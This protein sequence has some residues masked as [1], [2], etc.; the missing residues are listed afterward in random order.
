MSHYVSEVQK[1]LPKVNQILH[2]QLNTIDDEESRIE[3]KSR[4]ADVTDTSIVVEIPLNEKTGKLKK[5]YVG[6]EL[7]TFFLS[8]GG[9]KHYFTT[10]VT[11]F[12]E[13]VIRLVELRKPELE[14]IT[15]VQRR[16]FLRVLAELEIAVKISD[17]IQFIGVTDDV[18]GGGISFI[19]DGHI[20]LGLNAN[21][22]CWVLVPY[23]NGSIEHI[24]FTGEIVRIKKLESGKQLAMIRFIEIA[25]RERQKL[26]RFCFERQMDFRKR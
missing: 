10:S 14:A 25:D 7:S 23:K 11:G 19:C 15:Q 22:S 4:I 16:S 24:P 2:I 18:G 9:V 21:I 17:Q 20:P 1:L 26:I 5:L 8:Q 3:Y 12:K 13:D 6:D